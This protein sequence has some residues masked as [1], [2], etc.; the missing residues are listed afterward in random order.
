MKSKSVKKTTVEGTPS[1]KIKTVTIDNA[2]ILQT[3][4]VY[5]LSKSDLDDLMIALVN[6]IELTEDITKGNLEIKKFSIDITYELDG[7]VDMRQ[8][9]R[10]SANKESWR[11]PA[12]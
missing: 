12:L 3:K 4:S 11:R 7:K 5:V 9:Y 6:Y 2:S 10:G 1:N 8:S